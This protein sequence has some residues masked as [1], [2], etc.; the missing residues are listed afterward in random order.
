MQLVDNGPNF[1][2]YSQSGI[3]TLTSITEEIYSK[4]SR[5]RMVVTEQL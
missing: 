1:F 4:W 3:E 5:L 2:R